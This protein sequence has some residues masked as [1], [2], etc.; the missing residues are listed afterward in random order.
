MKRQDVEPGNALVTRYSH[1]QLRTPG[2]LL[3]GKI[4]PDCSRSVPDEMM[5]A[6]Q[7]VRLTNQSVEQVVNCF[8]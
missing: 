7:V 6:F 1:M 2:D 4:V 3:D 8:L 5:D